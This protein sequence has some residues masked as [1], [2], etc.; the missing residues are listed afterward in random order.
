MEVKMWV[1]ALGDAFNGI[2]IYGP[3]SDQMVALEWAEDQQRG[4]DWH[5]VKVNSTSGE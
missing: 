1:V 3:F 4:D 2:T 5:V